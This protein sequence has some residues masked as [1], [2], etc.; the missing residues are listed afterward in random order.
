MHY[1]ARGKVVSPPSSPGSHAVGCSWVPFFCHVRGVLA[2]SRC[3]DHRALA[4][5]LP[6]LLWYLLSFSKDGV[7]SDP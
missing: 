7:R 4:N 5:F 6:P 1:Y 2:E 3:L